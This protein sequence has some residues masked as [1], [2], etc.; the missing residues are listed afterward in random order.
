MTAL[1]EKLTVPSRLLQLTEMSLAHIVKKKLVI[2]I[3]STRIISL[4]SG[5]HHDIHPSDVPSI[6]TSV[7]SSLVWVWLKEG[8][9]SYV[10]SDTDT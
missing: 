1:C 10:T 8:T 7:S 6:L 3:G 4:C 2:S 9:P 5:I